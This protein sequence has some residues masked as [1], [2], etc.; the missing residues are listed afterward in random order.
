MPPKY[1]NK[2]KT[3]VAGSSRDNTGENTGDHFS[4][5]NYGQS[6]VM[7]IFI[8]G[9]HHFANQSSCYENFIEE[10]IKEYD[11]WRFYVYIHFKQG[12]WF[13]Y[14]GFSNLSDYVNIIL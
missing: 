1:A 2:P 4:R 13:L 7:I 11:L 8:N 3:G 6:I 12:L 14:S 5:N 9:P 10:I